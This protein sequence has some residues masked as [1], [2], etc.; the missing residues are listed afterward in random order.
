MTDVPP[1]RW[2]RTV[3]DACIAYQ[4]LGSGPV[5]LVVIHGW[6]SHLE[7]YWEQPR[8]RRFLRRLS[9][10]MRV[11]VFDKRGVGM[12]DR[13]QGTPD[14]GILADDVRAVMDAAG[15]HRAALVGWGW[16][17]PDLAAFFAATHPD[18][19]LCWLH[20]GQLH[21]RKE[22]D[23]PWGETEEE[24]ERA[25]AT[26]TRDWGTAE[27]AESFIRYG[28]W[29]PDDP[30]PM[31]IS[32]YLEP[33]FV[34]WNARLARFAAT[35]ASF[36][37]FERTWFETDVRPLLRTVSVPTGVLHSTLD[38]KSEDIDRAE[39]AMIPT[40]RL[41]GFDGHDVIPWVEDPD[42][43]VS[44][45]ER[46][47]ASVEHEEAQLDRV[48]A[49]VLFTDIC[50]STDK[51]CELGDV[52]W[53]ELLERHHQTSCALICR[54]RGKQ[55][56][57][58]GDGVLATFDGPARAVKCAQSICEAVRPL[59]IEI[60]A[61]CHTGEIELLG[62]EVGGVAVHIGAR[63][64][65]LSG[66]SEVLVTSTVK[67]LVAG[68]GLT[69]HDRGSHHLKGIPEPWRVWALDMQE[70]GSQR[71]PAGDRRQQR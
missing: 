6:V 5:T 34:T 30:E 32:P 21:G 43:F 36:E 69:F 11:L 55:V 10:G 2:A 41:V 37:A 23:Y 51:A 60:R 61:G 7:V 22:R 27:G 67:D 62:D 48:L 44:S 56:R 29:D 4:D 40:A 35:P 13:T 68:S 47:I 9:R 17:G 3:D 19:T 65:A 71:A 59:G 50:G 26:L 66:P 20:Y 54:Y 24:H 39:T 18:R 70:T 53:T 12:S 42:P 33:D 52:R 16:P 14:I 58:T 8:Y 49:T 57:T 25:I 1:T 15:V 46:F 64:G 45:I 28:Y 63:V 38:R 31:P